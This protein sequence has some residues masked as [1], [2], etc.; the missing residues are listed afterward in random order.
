MILKCRPGNNTLSSQR[1]HNPCLKVFRAL[2][3]FSEIHDPRN[4]QIL[5]RE[6]HC[7][8]ELLHVRLLKWLQLIW[9]CNTVHWQQTNS[10]CRVRGCFVYFC[11]A[12]SVYG[13]QRTCTYGP[14]MLSACKSSVGSYEG[15]K[16][17]VSERCKNVLKVYSYTVKMLHPKLWICVFLVTRVLSHHIFN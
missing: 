5:I 15:A 8:V 1:G 16:V 13:S 12:Q 9:C 4:H 3:P 17:F 10:D 11:T 2:F 7:F 6:I 14:I